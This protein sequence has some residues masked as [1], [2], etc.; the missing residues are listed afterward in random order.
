MKIQVE[1][2]TREVKVNQKGT[3]YTGI[4]IQGGDWVNVYGDHRGKKGQIIEI[5]DPKSYAGT[6]DTKWASVIT[7][8]RPDPPPAP[9]LPPS[10]TKDEAPDKLRG[11]ER[12]LQ[13]YMTTMDILALHIKKLEPDSPE[14]RAALIN[15]AMTLWTDG[16]I[17]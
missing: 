5:T 15:N 9:P 12:T 4:K 7:S 1:A 3:V 17:V 13:Q 14:A 8:P 2:T 16:K 11:F 6:G 10:A